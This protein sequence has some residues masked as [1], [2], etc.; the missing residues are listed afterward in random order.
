MADRYQNR[1]FPAGGDYDRDGSPTSN[2]D[3][4]PLAELARLIGQTDP[5]GSRPISRAN[6]PLQPQ[7]RPVD[8]EPSYDN[9]AEAPEPDEEPPPGPPSWMQR[10]VRQQAPPPPPPQ[11]DY[12][13]AVH[14]L[15]R[16]AAAHPPAEPDYDS[17][18]SFADSGHEPDLSRYDEALYGSLDS[19]AQHAQHDQGYADDSYGYE[20]DQGYEAQQEPR[21][22]GGGMITVGAVLALAVFGVGGAFAYRTYTGGVRSGP[23]PIIRAD[24]GP[25]KIIPA[26]ADAG[27]KV[28]D[29]MATSGGAEKMV[30]REE[31]PID[32][33]TRAGP[34]VVFPPL[35][36][37]GSVPLPAA[38]VPGG[39]PPPASSAA[40]GT[41]SN[42]EPHRIR[43]LSVRGDQA[44]AG[45]P[46]G[47]P[48]PPAK[49]APRAAT[50]SRLTA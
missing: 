43:T 24:A 27:A 42:N 4:D 31:T 21:R 39:G 28:P 16:Y 9:Y 44:E 34:R 41:F 13:A 29:R 36:P 33:S 15:H 32:P 40:S 8:P 46:A 6:L 3:S 11:D 38:V 35:T 2:A 23:P 47:A 48:P 18:E 12:P 30:S 7:A 45:L 10:A 25:T 22:R 49:P 19:R 20:E 50:S 37:N 1:S 5:F 14:P 26:S 17:E